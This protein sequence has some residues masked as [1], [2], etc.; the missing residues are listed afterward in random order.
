MR[1]V[2]WLGI[3]TLGVVAL[4]GAAA[5]GVLH[6]V[7]NND[8]RTWAEWGAKKAGTPVTFAGPV[9][10]K[11]WPQL[12]VKARGITVPA[13]QGEGNLAT[14]DAL[15]MQADWGS[16]FKPWQGL[17]VRALEAKNP[18]ITLT[19]TKEGIANWQ[20][21]TPEATVPTPATNEPGP[22]KTL[23]EKG[24]MLAALRLAIANLNLTYADAQ[25]GQQVTVKTMTISARTEGTV[26]TTSLKGT[27]NAQPLEGELVADVADLATIP[28]K[29][30]L[31][32]AGAALALDGRVMEQKGFA[33]LINARSGNLQ[34]TLKTLLGKAPAQA[35]AS[36]ASLT[37]DVV[38]G[39]EAVVLRNF[40]A[41]IGE[42]LQA[43]GEIDIALG[44]KPSGKGQLQIQGDNLR[45]LAELASGQPQT[46]LP[47]KPFNVQMRL[48]GQDAIEI[49]DMVFNLEPVL[50]ARGNATIT[51]NSSGQPDV[52]TKLTL[53]SP[54]LKSLLAA[55][56][57]RMEAPNAGLQATLNINGKGGVYTLENVAAA[58]SG[59]AQATATG[60]IDARSAQPSLNLDA[61]IEGANMA[62]AAAGFGVRGNLPASGFSLTGKV[63]GS[64]PY[65]LEGLTVNLPGLVQAL[66]NLTYSAGNPANLQGDVK[67]S[68]LDA[69]KLGYCGST[70]NP[71]N[72]GGEEGSVTPV[73]TAP[74]D[75]A[76]L[77]FSALRQ[78]G[79]NLKVQV[80][81]IRCSSV[82]L[83]NA[84][85]TVRNT[86][87][88]L[89]LENLTLDMANNGGRI[90]GGLSLS[91]A[92]T[93][94]LNT[95]LTISNL[96]T[97]Q[98][99]P[100]LAAKNVKLPV[101]GTVQL[102]SQGATTRALAQNLGGRT[103]LTATDG[104]LP[105]VNMLGNISTIQSLLQGQMVVPQNG[106]GKLDSLE[107][108]LVFRQGVGTFETLTAATG[109]GA[110]TLAGTGTINL[111]DWAIDVTLNPQ[112][113]AGSNTLAVPILVRGPLTAPAIGADPAFTQR[114]TSR[115]ATEGLKG[116]LGMDKEG[117]KGLG[118]VI[119]DV[120][121]G[122]GITQEGV[123]NLLNQFVKPKP[124]APVEASPT[125]AAEPSPTAATPAA[126]PLTPEDALKQALPGLLN[127]VLG[128]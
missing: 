41:R 32:G 43:R 72:S 29:A 59:I 77:D 19:R 65:E 13:L 105:Y 86:P 4:A 119:G 26:A 56:G 109:G 99:V 112:V 68:E 46:M 55:F 116:L 54:S 11:L 28:L 79:L 120:V 12:V 38:L 91:H 106:S 64:G 123:G 100:A 40:S 44:S 102:A 95:T 20:P 52:S 25:T 15:A 23:T 16:G 81:G 126:A 89:D 114:L 6:Y 51:P 36:P 24:G 17:Q 60:S 82:P 104:H 63:R 7:Q 67:I 8:M 85:M 48:A 71:R 124:A 10:V 5:Y 35:P 39:T 49:R 3:G 66:A 115:L 96:V 78:L 2:T 37:G 84:T 22:L 31:E 127:N 108:V 125:T 103:T 62:A 117:A 27:V 57:Q 87:S 94:K 30:K 33:G 9:E 45:A 88:Q 34:G 98:L 110:M 111:P 14:I 107:A 101:N 122:K 113:V 18:I 128:Q 69:T 83:D 80:N 42:L 97:E 90:T 70:T 76:P 75:D 93:P 61:K 121:G 21:A 1:L 73:T 58:I 47:A 92:G 50:I 118:G 74:W 53:Q